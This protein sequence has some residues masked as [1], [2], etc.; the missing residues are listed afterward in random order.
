V[1]EQQRDPMPGGN[2]GEAEHVH[3]QP[4]CR[5]YS[6]PDRPARLDWPAHAGSVAPFGLKVIEVFA[7]ARSEGVQ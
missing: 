7:R 2:L 4:C 3:A 5:L 6:A 1:L